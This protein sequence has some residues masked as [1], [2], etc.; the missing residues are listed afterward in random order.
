MRKDPVIAHA[1]SATKVSSAL[2]PALVLAGSAIA[3]GV[4]GARFSP[5]EYQAYFVLLALIGPLLAALQIVFFTFFD[6]DRLHSERHIEQKMILSRE[7]PQIGDANSVIELTPSSKL[8]ENPGA[9][10]EGDV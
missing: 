9:K 8:I 3:G 7:V 4:A 1:N 2:T 5:P 10:G 6:R